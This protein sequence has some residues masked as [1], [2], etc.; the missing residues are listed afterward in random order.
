MTKVTGLGKRE[1][2]FG[3][4][5]VQIHEEY[6]HG[7][8]DLLG[9]LNYIDAAARQRGKDAIMD[10]ISASL[11]RPVRTGPNARRDGG[12]AFEYRIYENAVGSAALQM[13]TDKLSLDCHGYVNTH[14]DAL[15]HLAWHGEW[16]NGQ[17]IDSPDRAG[18][19]FGM[20][21]HGIFT[22]G[23]YVDVAKAR[24]S[25]YIDEDVPVDG[26]DIERA[27]ALS[28]VTFEPGDA[29]LL[30]C[31]RDVYEAEV[32]EWGESEIRPGSGVGVAEWVYEN[33]PSLLLWDM[34]DTISPY[35]ISNAVHKAHWALGLVLVD[36]CSYEWARPILQ[37]RRQWTGGLALS[38]LLVR[39]A[40]GSNVNPMLI[41]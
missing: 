20:A 9:S 8:G 41:L 23:V 10:G 33:N 22:R 16:Y 31:G 34:M 1:E 21:Q 32:G 7:R 39:G 26:N 11:S 4:W 12:S 17:P 19:L 28:G 30:D 38:P 40:T 13:R 2:T 24:R 6:R 18:D 36:N 3:N 5:I 25:R 35:Q 27:L 14:I 29:L 15:N 37:Q